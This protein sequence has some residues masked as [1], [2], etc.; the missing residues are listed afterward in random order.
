[1]LGGFEWIAANYFREPSK[2]MNLKYLEYKISKEE[3][4]LETEP[5]LNQEQG[6]EDLKSNFLKRQNV[7][8]DLHRFRPTLLKALELLHQ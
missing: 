2:D 6:W 3:S 1:M 7:K 8:L 5:Q 4:I